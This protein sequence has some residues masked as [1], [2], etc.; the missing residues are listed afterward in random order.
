MRLV[1]FPY[2]PFPADTV[3][4]YLN[5]DPFQHDAPKCRGGSLMLRNRMQL[6]NGWGVDVTACPSRRGESLNASTASELYNHSFY[7]SI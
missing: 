1:E 5:L 4:Y 3:G 7:K 6:D 2:P